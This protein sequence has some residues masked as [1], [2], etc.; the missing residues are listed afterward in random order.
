ME[1]A[2]SS[3][4]ADQL[5]IPAL[6]RIAPASP[7]IPPQLFP[8]QELTRAPC[9]DSPRPGQPSFNTQPPADP[10]SLQQS[11]GTLSP[12]T[13]TNPSC[14]S[15]SDPGL[16]QHETLLPTP[17]AWRHP[18]SSTQP[19]LSPALPPAVIPA[20]E[21][22]THQTPLGPHQPCLPLSLFPAQPQPVRLAHN[23]PRAATAATPAQRQLPKDSSRPGFSAVALRWL[24][25][26]AWPGLPSPRSGRP[27]CPAAAV[28]F[29]R[30]AR[31]V[32]TAPPSGAG[33]GWGEPSWGRA[34]SP[35]SRAEGPGST[36][37]PSRGSARWGKP[38]PAL[39]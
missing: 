38:L 20:S 17:P 24:A 29:P 21:P 14:S 22:L 35:Q 6:T 39:L 32:A 5:S 25:V 37:G 15:T 26:P 1:L 10:E 23:G 19:P 2:Q 4:Q 7:A 27:W 9:S 18:H 3:G 34:G 31:P 13:Q 16:Q 30:R 36:A 28:R 12:Q 11:G 33:P 8:T